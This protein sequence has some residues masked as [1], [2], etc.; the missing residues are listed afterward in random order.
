MKKRCLILASL[1]AVFASHLCLAQTGTLLYEVTGK[2]LKKPSYILGTFH[3]I[4]PN[5]MFPGARLTS[6]IAKAD[7][8]IL[9]LDMDDPAVRT[10]MAPHLMMPAGKT[11]REFYTDAE[12]TKIDELFKSTIGA[13]V[14]Y[15]K[16][17]KPSMLSVMVLTNPKLVGCKTEA[18]DLLVV[19]AATAAK[20]SISGLETVEVQVA[21][22]DSAPLE[23]Q[24]RDL[25]DLAANPEKSI[26]ELKEMM[27]V[28]KAQDSEKLFAMTD[29]QMKN[30]GAFR[31]KLLDDR[32]RA[33]IPKLEVSMSKGSVFVAVGAGH[34]GGTN[35][36]VKLL[37]A[38]GYKLKPILL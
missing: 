19:K 26:G 21:A 34:L 28:Y 2:K 29:K 9:E 20:K 13:S 23:K 14:D 32:N 30:E 24:A 4:C 25:Y 37:K 36:V 8:V 11:L 27:D 35:G 7:D 18:V 12:Y 5:D 22:I 33:W 16:A 6:Y 15:L 1:F 17:F 38:R 3:A 31:T 10:S